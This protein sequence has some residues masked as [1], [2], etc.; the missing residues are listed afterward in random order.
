M[1]DEDRVFDEF[2]DLGHQFLNRRLILH[3]LIGD[4]R[5]IDDHL[6]DFHPWVDKRIK[7]LRDGAVLN[8]NT[9]EF[10]HAVEHAR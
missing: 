7:T 8:Q 3:H 9:A 2:L 4:V 1:G 10:G 6:R 5:L